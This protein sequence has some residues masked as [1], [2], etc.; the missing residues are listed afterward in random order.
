MPQIYVASLSDYNAGVHHGRWIDCTIGFAAVQEEID[1]MLAESTTARRT[2][3][4]AEEWAIHDYED[5]EGYEVSENEDLETLCEIAEGIDEEGEP[6]AAFVENYHNTSQED[7]RH[8]YQ[9]T[10][11]SLEEWAED[12]LEEAGTLSYL[13]ENLRYYFDF[14][15]FARDCELN[16]DIWT[17][18]VSDGVAVFNSN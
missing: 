10:F 4:P 6:Y 11:N 7:F 13:P 17:A 8:A 12:Y 15:A 5:F 2:G 9:G 3:L 18:D 14:E 1:A 16:G